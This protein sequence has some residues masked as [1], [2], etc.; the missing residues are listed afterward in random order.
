MN[1][2]VSSSFDSWWTVFFFFTC[3]KSPNLK[4]QISNRDILKCYAMISGL[5]CKESAELKGDDKLEWV[6]EALA[7]F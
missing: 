5:I 4:S 7:Q 6:D 1:P 3:R 2:A